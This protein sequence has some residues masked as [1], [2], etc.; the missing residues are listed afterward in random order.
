MLD[1]IRLHA[2]G[3]LPADYVANLGEPR[4]VVFDARCCR[5]LGVPYGELRARTLAGGCDEEV[6]AWA[7]GRGTARS[8]EDCLVWNNFM[9]K[10][11]WR[12]D[13]TETLHARAAEYGLSPGSVETN[14]ELIDVDEGRPAGATRSWEDPPVRVVIVMGVSGCG[15]STVGRALAARLGWEFLDADGLHPP[16][17]VAKMASGIPPERCRPGPLA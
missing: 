5:F 14:F 7:R 1:K 11:G 4:P 9:A 2:R 8:E 6:L 15:K 13:R 17:N 3:L 10:L 12:D 16:S